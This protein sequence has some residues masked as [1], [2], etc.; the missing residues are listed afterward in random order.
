MRHTLLASA[1]LALLLSHPV[2]AAAP[3]APSDTPSAHGCH[4]KRDDTSAPAEE[5]C[6]KHAPHD[7]DE[8]DHFMPPPPH[9]PP[10]AAVKA[11]IGKKVG[12]KTTIYFNG[13][14][15]PAICQHYDGMILAQPMPPSQP[16]PAA[17]PR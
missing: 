17:I 15:I 7:A 8:H 6:S 14:S 1:A 4:A 12:H 3:P 16:D 13:N 5:P 2:Y 11:C 10:L 9:E